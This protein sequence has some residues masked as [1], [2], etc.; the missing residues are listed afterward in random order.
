MREPRV[1][2]KQV[3]V[4]QFFSARNEPL[5]FFFSFSYIIFG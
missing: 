5:L 4:E 1:L 2:G 3:E